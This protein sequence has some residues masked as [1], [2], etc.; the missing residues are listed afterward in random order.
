MFENMSLHV[1]EQGHVPDQRVLVDS[2]QLVLG[3]GEHALLSH[4]MG[5]TFRHVP[6]IRIAVLAREHS[7]E[8]QLIGRQQGTD[9]RFFAADEEAFALEWLKSS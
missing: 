1:A 5:L 7:R 2:R 3:V 8:G 4:Q 6:G 9:M